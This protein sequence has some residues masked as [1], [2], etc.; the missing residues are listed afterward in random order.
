CSLPDVLRHLPY[1]K[2]PSPA[3]TLLTPLHFMP[4]E[5]QA[6]RGTNIYG[7]TCDRQESC[8]VDWSQYQTF[9]RTVHPDRAERYTW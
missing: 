2:G 3:D 6:F 7:A 4:S 5:L 8:S 9:I 1:L